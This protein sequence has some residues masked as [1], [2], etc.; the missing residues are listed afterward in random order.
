[1]TEPHIALDCLYHLI[2]F[3][4]YHGGVVAAPVTQDLYVFFTPFWWFF[5]HNCNVSK[6][7]RRK[8]GRERTSLKQ[9]LLLVRSFLAREPKYLLIVNTKV[10][11]ELTYKLQ[12][13]KLRI[14]LLLT[15]LNIRKKENQ[16]QYH[17]LR[18]R[19]VV[20]LFTTALHSTQSTQSTQ[21][22]ALDF[23]F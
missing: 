13:C 20:K 22:T 10:I 12:L 14:L 3:I 8:Y 7:F 23:T 16:N 19:H 18:H 11:V 4:S 21:S 1:M 6:V 15:K 17:V 5:L 9:H 2:S